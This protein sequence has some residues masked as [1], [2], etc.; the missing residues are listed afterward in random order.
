MS[1]IIRWKPFRDYFNT[2]LD[3]FFDDIWSPL[4][5]SSFVGDNA[6]ALDV[7]ESSNDYTVVTSMPGVKPDDIHVRLDN[8]VLTISGEVKQ[9]SGNRRALIQERYYGRFSRSIRLPESVD[10]K[11]AEAVYNNGVLTLT[12]PKAASAKRSWRI[13]VKTRGRNLPGRAKTFGRLLRPVIQQV[14]SKLLP[15]PS[16]PRALLPRRTR[17]TA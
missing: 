10:S 12:L 16:R 2:S 11:N 1:S 8:D 17:N 4:V 15:A 14:T 9:S 13:P 7:R 6:L 5:P 3:S